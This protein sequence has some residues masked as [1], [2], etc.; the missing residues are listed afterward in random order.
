MAKRSTGGSGARSGKAGPTPSK[1]DRARARARAR[2][3][4]QLQWAMVAVLVAVLF[5][6][7]YAAL[8]ALTQDRQD[9]PVTTEEG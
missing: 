5:I 6:G 8:Q 4:T 7:S 2:R 1:R 3:R 9:A